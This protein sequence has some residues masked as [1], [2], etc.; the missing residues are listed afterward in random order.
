MNQAMPGPRG[1]LRD[2]VAVITGATRGIGRAVAVAFAHEGAAVVVDICAPVY[3]PS[4]VKPATKEDLD[5]RDGWSRQ[6]MLA[7]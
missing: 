1:I 7:G 4:G 5:G 6:P 3:P 2:K